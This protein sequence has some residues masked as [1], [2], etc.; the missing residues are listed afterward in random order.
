MLGGETV[1]FTSHGELQNEAE[2]SGESQGHL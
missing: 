1:E 2:Y